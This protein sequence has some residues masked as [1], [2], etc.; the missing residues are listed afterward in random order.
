MK[1]EYHAMRALRV[2]A[3]LVRAADTVRARIAIDGRPYLDV[4]RDPLAASVAAVVMSPT[5]YHDHIAHLWHES[6]NGAGIT[7]NTRELALFIGLR[8]GDREVAGDLW[9]FSAPGRHTLVLATTAPP[10]E[11][12]A[13]VAEHRANATR[14]IC[15]IH[16][17]GVG[18]SLVQ[19]CCD[20]APIARAYAQALMIEVL[21]GCAVEEL[22]QDWSEFAA[23]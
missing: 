10:E 2:S 1:L 14:E 23:S 18:V 6:T 16:D 5:E 7:R 19:T 22:E 17:P 12:E 4:V 9:E 13:V 11:V 20:D 3:A 21:A 8:S 15:I